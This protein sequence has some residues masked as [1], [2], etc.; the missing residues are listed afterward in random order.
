MTARAMLQRKK[1][2]IMAVALSGFVLAAVGAV[3]AQLNLVPV[4]PHLAVLPGGVLFALALLYGHH[5]AFRCPLCGER[6]GTL[7]M[8]GSRSLLGIDRR[9]RYC[10]FCGG[11]INAELVTE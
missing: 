4:A 3:L 7:A 2:R 11:D 10:P 9:I 6:W 5:L 1:W 8:N